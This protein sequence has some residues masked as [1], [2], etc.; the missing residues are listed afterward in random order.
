MIRA[1]AQ[2]RFAARW[3]GV[4]GGR[5][6]AGVRA[7]MAAA[8]LAVATR[9]HGAARTIARTW[10]SYAHYIYFPAA[11]AMQQFLRGR[12]DHKMR[13]RRERTAPRVRRICKPG[14]DPTAALGS[15]PFDWAGRFVRRSLCLE[16]R[17]CLG[18]VVSR[19][20]AAI[21]LEAFA[22]VVLGKAALGRVETKISPRIT[23]KYGLKDESKR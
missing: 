8:A 6:A 1:D 7:A 23:F 17:T 19:T 3:R 2:T 20:G 10:R 4:L 16:K 21:N 12:W 22:R 11:Y 9:R 13:W 14:T 18:C 5:K 15:K